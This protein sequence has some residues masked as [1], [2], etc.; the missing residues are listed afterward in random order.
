MKTICLLGILFSFAQ[1][2]Q[3]AISRVTSGSNSGDGAWTTAI[4]FIAMGDWGT[5]TNSGKRRLFE[6]DETE[7]L[8]EGNGNQNNNNN[9]NNNQ[10]NNKN[11]NNN[12][13][14]NNNNNG[15][16]YWNVLVA[17]AMAEY[18]GSNPADF[19]IALGDNFYSSG[20]S[21]TS[22]SLWTSLYSNIYNYDSL[23]VPWYA[24]F[25]NHD[26]GSKNGLGSLQAQIDFG[27]QKYD[28]KWNAG[29]CYLK[30]FTIPD[31]TTDLDVV[32]IDTTLIAPEETYVTSRSSGISQDA[33]TA[34]QQEQLDCLEAYLSASTAEFLVVAGH[35]PMFS[36]GKN[37]PGDMTTMVEL[38]LPSFEKYQVD[39]YL[40][41]H[42][43]LLEHLV[44][45]DGDSSIDFYVSGA[46][47]KP[48]N[49]LASGI[50]SSADSRF[51][52]ATGGFAFF[53]VTDFTMNVKFI[54]YTG[55]ELYETTR[56]QV[57]DTSGSGGSTSG[58][59]TTEV[60]S[61]K[62]ATGD[63]RTSPTSS[64]SSSAT[65]TLT[66][67]GAAQ[68]LDSFSLQSLALSG[69]VFGFI[70]AMF[71]VSLAVYTRSSLL[72]SPKVFIHPDLETAAAGAAS[73]TLP[74]R[75]EVKRPQKQKAKARQLVDEDDSN[76]VETRGLSDTVHTEMRG[77]RIAK[78]ERMTLAPD[79]VT[80]KKAAASVYTLGSD[81]GASRKIGGVLRTAPVLTQ[82]SRKSIKKHPVLQHRTLHAVM[83]VS[84]SGNGTVVVPANTSILHGL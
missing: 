60:G 12:N 82:S 41:G 74:S 59:G 46:A 20:V 67:E 9:Q 57:R 77:K 38:L 58:A 19:L 52:A 33:Q 7:L 51:A 23:Q 10:N 17:K 14:N 24:I 8:A 68:F 55:T 48:D 43:H 29:Y 37:S 1:S 4:H 32:F 54:D 28:E 44:Y 15:G 36:I 53:E 62:T 26:Y 2:D 71:I 22:D 73:P 72:S 3:K 25:G 84:Q 31:S 42:D 81:N 65:F 21:S 66:M 75:Y 56:Y 47:G 6:V 39:A 63:V 5:F 45:T 30:S 78:E 83:N 27:E 49:Q 70:A 50:T 69:V 80:A 76:T 79:S 13:K 64:P 34:K 35:Y 18:A 40:A 11:N 16:A 61:S